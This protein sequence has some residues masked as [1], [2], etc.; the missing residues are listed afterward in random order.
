MK[1]YIIE[2]VLRLKVEAEDDEQAWNDVTYMDFPEFELPSN[3][4]L[5]GD[6]IEIIRRSVVSTPDQNQDA[7]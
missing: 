4:T 5:L 3:M 1:T 2:C 6:E 7:G